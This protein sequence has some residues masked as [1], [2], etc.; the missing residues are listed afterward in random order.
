[1]ISAIKMKMRSII[2]QICMISA[3]GIYSG[4]EKNRPFG[5]Q[6]LLNVQKAANGLPHHTQE[7]NAFEWPVPAA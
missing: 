4:A 3:Y 7:A 2:M 5:R 1:M 6:V